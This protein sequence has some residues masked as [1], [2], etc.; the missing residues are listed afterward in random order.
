MNNKSVIE[1]SGAGPAGL[2]AAMAVMT[3]GQ[4]ALVYERHSDVGGRFHGDFQGL[5]NWSTRQD[6]LDELRSMDI[7]TDFEHTPVH[8]VVCFDPAG[9]ARTF[10][11]E[12]PLFYL[13]RR[14]SRPGSLDHALKVQALAE[15][16]E[17]R[18]NAPVKNLPNGGV[19]SEGPHRA[20]IIAVGYLFDTNM[21]DGIYAVVSD[22]LAPKGY[23]YLLINKGRGTLATCLFDDFHKERKYL[24]RCVTFFDDKV[25]VQ[26]ENP[27]R[28]GGSGNFSSSRKV[29][30]GNILYAGETAGFQDPLFGFGIRTALLSGTAA[31]RAQVIED[32]RQFGRNWKRRLRPYYQT[33][34][35]N[36]WFYDRLGNRGYSLTLKRF[37]ADADV[38]DW[39][40]RAYTP[41]LWKRTW[42]HLV[43]SRRETPLLNFHE[44][45]DCTWCRCERHRQNR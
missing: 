31:G 8:K 33:A 27:H 17:I 44:G 14:G 45:C 22:Y 1:I 5:E 16:V 32:P 23:A 4:Q 10:R 13:V 7:T 30:K 15:G 37:P 18:F 3:A 25:G 24:E 2:A 39:M 29:H 34:V 43:A 40:Y 19:V 20:D 36:R 35:T 42:Y 11:S 26:M 38:R 28:F 9:L 21:A 12:K 41:R 6:V